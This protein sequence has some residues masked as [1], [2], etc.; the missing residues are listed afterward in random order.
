M[1]PKVEETNVTHPYDECPLN[2]P[3]W[4]GRECSAA[5]LGYRTA[6]PAMREHFLQELGE[7]RV[8]FTDIV[9][10]TLLEPDRDDG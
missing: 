10:M 8:Y 3:P 9:G 5:E 6:A 4:S 7:S 2:P 1:F